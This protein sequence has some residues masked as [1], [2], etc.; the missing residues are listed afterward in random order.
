[1]IKTLLFIIKSSKIVFGLFFISALIACSNSTQNEAVSLVKS[2]IKAHGGQQ[3]YDALK[4]ISFV[5]TSRLFLEDGSI[6]YEVVQK[7]SFQFKPDYRV[8]IEWQKK[9]STHVIFYNGN[10]A[11]KTIDGKVITDS[12]EIVKAKNTAKAAAYVF[13]QPFGLVDENTI[14]SLENNVQLNDSVIA[15]AVSVRY[16]GDIKESDKWTFY[17]NDDD[18]LIANSVI[19]T[20]HKSLIENLELQNAYGLVFNKHR[21]SY[22]VDSLLNKKYLRAEYYYDNLSISN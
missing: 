9:G 6:D 3:K 4:S 14:L 1:M 7:Q 20:D 18:I 5:K 8:Q 2:S 11:I 22:R 12:L 21:K 17:F 16:K 13:F 15:Q 19:L 10:N